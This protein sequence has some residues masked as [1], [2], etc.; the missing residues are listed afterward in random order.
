M[1]RSRL[2]FKVYGST[3]N[4]IRSK[5]LEQLEQFT[6]GEISEHTTANVEI[7]ITEVE[8]SEKVLY[9]GVVYAKL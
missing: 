8:N 9:V 4:E 1:I 7:D 5:A 6:G 3:D 2:T